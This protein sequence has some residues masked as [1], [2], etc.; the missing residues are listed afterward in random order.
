MNKTVKHNNNPCLNW[1]VSNVEVRIDNAGKVMPVKT[2]NEKSHGKANWR[3]DAA[4]SL[5]M[6]LDGKLRNDNK[7]EIEED[8][9]NMSEHIAAIGNNRRFSL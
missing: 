6:A 8:D 2:K 7:N 3:I 1:C 9:W 5:I 4:V